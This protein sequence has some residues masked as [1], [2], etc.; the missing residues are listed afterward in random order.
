MIYLHGVPKWQENLYHIAHSIQLAKKIVSN[1]A[2]N[3]STLHSFR[4]AEFIVTLVASGNAMKKPNPKKKTQKARDRA[5][6]CTRSLLFYI[7]IEHE[8]R[9]LN[10]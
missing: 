3:Y 5:K 2:W 8:N 10:A 9:D 6:C 7:D 1:N 4:C